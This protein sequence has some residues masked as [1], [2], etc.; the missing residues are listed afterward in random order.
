[1]NYGE[2]ARPSSRILYIIPATQKEQR[3]RVPNSRIGRNDVGWSEK[4][5]N[6]SCVHRRHREK[7]KSFGK[8]VSQ[9]KLEIAFLTPKL[10][11]WP[12]YEYTSKA[13]LFPL[14]CSLPMHA[15]VQN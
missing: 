6:L 13:A 1:M 3:F 4:G 10:S 7:K 14:L 9:L 8:N 12:P 5:I 15:G 11:P 2:R